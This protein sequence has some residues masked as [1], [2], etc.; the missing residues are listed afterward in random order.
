M[1]RNKSAAH[2]TRLGP[3]KGREGMRTQQVSWLSRVGGRY[4]VALKSYDGSSDCLPGWS[5][6]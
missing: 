5:R 4:K 6:P 3:S 1:K 2:R